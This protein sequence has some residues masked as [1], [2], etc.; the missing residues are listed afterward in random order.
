MTDNTQDL[1]KFLATFKGNAFA[2]LEAV[3]IPKMK[4]TDNPYFDKVVKHTTG[5]VMLGYN[6][7]KSVNNRLKNEGKEESFQPESLPWG[8]WVDGSKCLIEHKGNYYVRF[9]YVNPKATIQTSSGMQE[10]K[11]TFIKS[12][13]QLNHADIALNILDKVKAFFPKRYGGRQGTEN[14]VMIANYGIG[15]IM[16][17]KCGEF[18]YSAV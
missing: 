8:Q 3:T 9:T 16:S 7:G 11:R 10:I 15:S 13:Y 12:V 4:K 17:F 14:P 5:L 1:I 6:Y 2:K 18:E